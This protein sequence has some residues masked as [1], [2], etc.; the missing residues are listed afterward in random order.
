[1]QHDLPC[2]WQRLIDGCPLRNSRKCDHY[3]FHLRR[4]GKRR[5]KNGEVNKQ[6]KNE[7]KHTISERPESAERR[8]E[9]GHWEGD[10]VIGRRGGARLVTQVDRKSRF[11]LAVKIPNS[12][13]ETVRDALIRMLKELPAEKLRSITQDREPEFAKHS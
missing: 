6:G 9:P 11:L 12:T 4:K 2:D 13:A 3:S 8:S 1:M 5:K 7:I 10:T